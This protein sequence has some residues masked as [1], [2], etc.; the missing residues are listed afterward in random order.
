M[1]MVCRMAEQQA[2][3]QLLRSISLAILQEGGV[4]RSFTNLGDRVLTRNRATEDNVIHGVG[5]FMEVQFYSNPNTL[6]EAEK[7][8]RES[9]ETLRVFS[10]KMKD[11]DYLHRLL[12]KVNAELSPFKD[13]D[14]RD[15]LFMREM[16]DHY[17]KFEDFDVSTS[18]RQIERNSEE[19]HSYLKQMEVGSEHADAKLLKSLQEGE[20]KRENK[21]INSYLVKRLQAIPKA[22]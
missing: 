14:Q 5:R 18:D 6:A 4:V 3:T 12:G 1:V 19:V 7:I 16:L 9:Q 2:M 13:E 20:I 21:R 8:A 17:R 15:S 22:M 10:L 11:D